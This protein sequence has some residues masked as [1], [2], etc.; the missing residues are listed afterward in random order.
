MFWEQM[1]GFWVLNRRFKGLKCNMAC[2]AHE[3][4]LREKCLDTA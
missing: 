4:Y 1:Y 2:M 3:R